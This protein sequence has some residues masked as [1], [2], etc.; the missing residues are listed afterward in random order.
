MLPAYL[1]NPIAALCG[2][3]APIDGGRLYRDG[4]RFFGD[5]KTWRGLFAGILAGVAAGVL[6]IWAAGTYGISMLPQQTLLSVAL[7]SV[8]ALLGDLAKS[9]FKRRLGKERG[10]KWPIADQYD[11]VAGAFLLLLV[12]NPA[13]LFSEVTLPVFICILII[14]PLLHRVTNIIGYFLKVKEVPW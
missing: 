4:R 5:G 14:T 3:G 9:F 1:P 13:W 8:G 6:Q 11:L 7:L 12:F 2:G 10:A